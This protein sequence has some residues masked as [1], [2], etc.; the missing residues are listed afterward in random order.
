MNVV[1][2]IAGRGS[3]FDPLT[4]WL[5]K[6]LVPVRQRP[7]I[8]WAMDA[9]RGEAHRVIVV[10]NDR[11]RAMLDPALDAVLGRHAVRVWTQDTAGAPHT[12]LRA[13]EHIDNTDDLL[14]LTPDM[15]WRADLTPVREGDADAALVVSTLPLRDPVEARRRYSYC[16]IAE[17][18][19]V[20]SVVEKPDIPLRLA[21]VGA[22]WWR[23]GCDFITCAEQHLAEGNTV[24]GETYIAPVYN[25]AIEAGL[26]VRAVCATEYVNLG[27]AE[28]AARWEGWGE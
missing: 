4:R 21:N 18:G 10:A 7:L 3:R 24:R 14:I 27:S 16:R 17:D 25:T 28:R 6:C 20:T 1:L 8:A 9:L 26:V 15:L 2:P 13:R 23:R 5:P 22:Y 11:E 12:V 19:R